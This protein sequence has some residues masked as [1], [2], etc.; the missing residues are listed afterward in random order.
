[1]STLFISA[2]KVTDDDD[3]HRIAD[4]IAVSAIIVQDLRHRRNKNYKFEWDK[5][6]QFKGDTGYWIQY[7]H[8]RLCR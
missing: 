5:M 4:K 1:M 8:C 7:T 3:I 6:L 2:T